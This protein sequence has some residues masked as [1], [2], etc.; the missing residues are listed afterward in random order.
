MWLLYY[1][2]TSPPCLGPV[3]H[4]DTPVDSHVDSNARQTETLTELKGE[5]E[6]ARRGEVEAKSLLS[7]TIEELKQF[8][9]KGDEIDAEWQAKFL[10]TKDKLSLADSE[11]L[12]LQSKYQKLLEECARTEE[13]RLA[14]E[15]SVKG[16]TALLND[17]LG[18]CVTA[19][20]VCMYVSFM[21]DH[22]HTCD[23]HVCIR[24][25]VC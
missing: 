19:W 1:T 16:E 12:S 18:K 17:K 22:V 25:Y 4:C 24:M 2:S 6:A 21:L 9:G 5:L 7:T 11:L 14:L 23:M 10:V 15:Q 8:K 3:H 13:T 20:F